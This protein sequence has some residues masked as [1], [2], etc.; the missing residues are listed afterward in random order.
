[1]IRRI[2]DGRRPTSINLGLGEPGFPVETALL[3]AGT[4]RFREKRPGY[5]LNP[6]MPELRQLVARYFKVPHVPDA[7]GVIITAGAA[8]ALYCVLT[9]V[10]DPGDEIVI[11][12][13]TF[14]AN[15]TVAELLGLSV[16]AVPLDR[17][18]GFA[19]DVEA[20]ARAITPRTRA[21]ILNSP[22]NPTGRVDRI[23]ELRALVDATEGSGVW[24]ISDEVYR[25]IFFTPETPASVGHLSERGI[26]FGSLSKSCSMTGFRLGYVLSPAP[27]AKAISAVHQFTVTCA[28][29]ISQHLALEAFEHPEQMRVHLP[30]YRQQRSAILN[31]VDRELGLPVVPPEGG[32]Y[33]F[34]DVRKLQIG[35]VELAEKLL[36]DADVVTVPGLA[37]GDNG[38]GFLRLSYAG[39]E[40]DLVEGVRR[41]GN[42]LRSRGGAT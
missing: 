40:A 27:L 5:T 18:H 11:L 17:E 24:L 33:L 13:P 29:T 22:C 23:D 19:L 28:P 8:E 39:Q 36:A 38:E 15:R 12:D 31:A 20:I 26:V 25:E 3:D 21:V 1:M 2:F 4:A 6:G 9:A 14:L 37:F 32:F 41:I 10:A 7:G 42:F 16:V 30:R 34:V 35:S